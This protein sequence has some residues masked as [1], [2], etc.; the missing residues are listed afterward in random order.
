LERQ[1]YRLKKNALFRETENKIVV[2]AQQCN[3]NI[4]KK[5]GLWLGD[6]LCGAQ[7]L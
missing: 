6:S 1:F 5:R 3:T 4:E 7:A 2:A